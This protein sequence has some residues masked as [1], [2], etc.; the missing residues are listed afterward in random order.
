VYVVFSLVL[1]FFLWLGL[2]WPSWRVDL[3]A[4]AGTAAPEAAAVITKVLD[5]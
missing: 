2:P 3:V 5:N 1:F 4:K